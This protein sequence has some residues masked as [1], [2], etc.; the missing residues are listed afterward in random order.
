MS[1]INANTILELFGLLPEADKQLVRK[2]IAQPKQMIS[3]YEQ[4]RQVVTPALLLKKHRSKNH[5]ETAK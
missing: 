3:S 2:A 1:A 4:K 5:K